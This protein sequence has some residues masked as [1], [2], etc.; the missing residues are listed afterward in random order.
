MVP[1]FRILFE[2]DAL[3]STATSLFTII[4]TSISGAISHIRNRTCLP[5][6]GIALGGG[7]ALTSSLGV[8][9][10]QASPSWAVMLAAAAVIAYSAITMF[11]K[12][13]A[14]G[15]GKAKGGTGE[16]MAL[17]TFT[18]KQLAIA[19]AIGAAAGFVSGYVGVGGGFIMVPLMLSVLNLPMRI[20]SGTSLVAVMMLA[21]PAT[22]AQCLLGNVDFI[23]GIATACGSIPGAL[24]GAR[25]VNRVPERTLRFLFGGFLVIAA[26]LLVVKELG[27]FA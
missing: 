4:P 11:R 26:I 3:A 5:K 9:A 13:L 14:M 21:T 12:A 24:L 18:V 7:G 20:A 10:A 22:I 27:L 19:V 15:S 2:L 25:L 8:A 6:L 23:V 1:T 17:R 16:D